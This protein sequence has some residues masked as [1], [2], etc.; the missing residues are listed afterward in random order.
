MKTTPTIFAVL[1]GSALVFASPMSAGDAAHSKD[2][3]DAPYQTKDRAKEHGSKASKEQGRTASSGAGQQERDMNRDQQSRQASS[4]QQE[5]RN[6][7]SQQA[8]RVHL[9]SASDLVGRQVRGVNGAELG[10]VSDFAI[11]KDADGA[12]KS[13]VVISRGGVLGVGADSYFVPADQLHLSKQDGVYESQLTVDG[14]SELRNPE[15]DLKEGQKF[16]NFSETEDEEITGPEGAQIGQIEDVLVS[17]DGK[18][19]YVLVSPSTDPFLVGQG[20]QIETHWAVPVHTLTEINADGSLETSL[21]LDEMT[22]AQDATD[23]GWVAVHAVPGEP[24]SFT[25]APSGGDA[26][27]DEVVLDN[28]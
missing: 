1:A 23:A 3:N 11:R 5:D 13:F 16:V 28:M 22:S 4:Q 18:A 7:E 21:S 10:S 17:R 6:A 24:R 26:G 14:L 27:E 8:E 20:S 2:K 9:N 19:A 12:F 15:Q 25:I